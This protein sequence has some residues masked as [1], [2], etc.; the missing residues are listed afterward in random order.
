MTN[1]LDTIEANI[2]ALQS[3]KANINYTHSDYL[4]EDDA[5]AAFSPINRT[6][7]SYLSEDDA[8]VSFVSINRLLRGDF[9]FGPLSRLKIQNE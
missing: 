6:H 3:G 7:S 8:V 9:F 2:A 5:V 1:D 4:S